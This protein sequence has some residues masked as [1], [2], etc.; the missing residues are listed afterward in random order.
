MVFLTTNSNVD[1]METVM[2]HTLG[3]DWKDYFDIC[4]ANARKPLFYR[5]ESPFYE[6]T[7]NTETRKGNKIKLEKVQRLVDKDVKIVIEGNALVLTEYFSRYIEKAD[8]QRA[9]HAAAGGKPP[10]GHSSVSSVQSPVY[11]IAS[12]SSSLFALN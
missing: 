2:R 8:A 9:A 7:P 3:E 4:V 6:Y 1:Y 10:P 11:V 12:L 5:A